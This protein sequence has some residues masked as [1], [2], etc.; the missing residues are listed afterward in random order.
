[1]APV[2][3]ELRPGTLPQLF[4]DILLVA[5]LAV[6]AARVKFMRKH[7]V[8]LSYCIAP[9]LPQGSRNAHNTRIASV[10]EHEAEM[11]CGRRR[12]WGVGGCMNR[13]ASKAA[14]KQSWRIWVTGSSSAGHERRVG[15]VHLEAS[16][17]IRWRCVD[18]QAHEVIVP[19]AQSPLVVWCRHAKGDDRRSRPQKGAGDADVPRGCDEHVGRLK[20][21]ELLARRHR[22]VHT[23]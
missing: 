15:W 17:R 19:R 4:R 10:S 12:E 23:A 7:S 11:A 2:V 13:E 22:L 21:S 5:P 16:R 6:I 20:P 1:M 18:L 3:E 8:D 9:S 14:T